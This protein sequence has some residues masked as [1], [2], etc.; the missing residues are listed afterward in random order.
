MRSALL[1]ALSSCSLQPTAQPPRGL[2]FWDGWPAWPG[3][4]GALAMP[5]RVL[6]SPALPFRGQGCSGQQGRSLLGWVPAARALEG[7]AA[8]RPGPSRRG[9][10]IW[11]S[12]R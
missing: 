5:P 4:W 12:G 11:V 1:A 6:A 9:H 7:A 3:S 10:V 2:S 8:R